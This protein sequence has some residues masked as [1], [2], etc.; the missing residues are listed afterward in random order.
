MGKIAESL[1]GSFLK[2]T[3]NL[4]ADDVAQAA[5]QFTEGLQGD[6]L[7]PEEIAEEANSIDVNDRTVRIKLTEVQ[8]KAIADMCPEFVPRLRLPE[9][10]QRIIELRQSELNRVIAEASRALPNGVSTISLRQSPTASTPSIR[11]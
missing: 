4:K 6:M 1:I 5:A 11:R 9:K 8:R 3:Q 10:N 2:E 7:S